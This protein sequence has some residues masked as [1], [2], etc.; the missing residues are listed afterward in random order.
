MGFHPD[1]TRFSVGVT[2]AVKTRRGGAAP[3]QL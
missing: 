1:M 2:G 3:A